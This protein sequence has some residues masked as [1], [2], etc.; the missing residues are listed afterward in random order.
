MAEI[1]SALELALE[2]AEQY[3]RATKEELT[4]DRYRDQGRQ[5]AV[6]FLKDGGDLDAALGSIPAA[7]QGEARGAIKEVLL[8]NIIL[9]RNGEIDPRMAQALEGL[10]SVAQDK[11][12]M[13]RQKAE[14]EQL[15][16]NF[17]QVRNNAYQ[18]L[19]ARFGAGI[20]QMQR[21]LEAQM[22][23]R[24]KLEVEQLPQFQEEWR[25]FQGQLLDQFEPVLEDLKERMMRA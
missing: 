9:P 24:V 6:D 22:R 17:L 11:K 19:K 13:A 3:G 23:Q 20:G 15:L 5:L 10:M 16:Q 21:A 25:K 8:R 2:K 7:A 12:A 1:K 4:R 18:Q 14:L